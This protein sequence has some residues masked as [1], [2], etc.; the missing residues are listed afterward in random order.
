MRQ[1]QSSWEPQLPHH[2]PPRHPVVHVL[3]D[4]TGAEVAART[5]RKEKPHNHLQ[6]PDPSPR[7]DF[8]RRFLLPQAAR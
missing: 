5:G 1:G 8:G 6:M 7:V 4:S 2:L 3:L